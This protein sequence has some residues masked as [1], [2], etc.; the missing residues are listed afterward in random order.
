MADR[1]PGSDSPH[2]RS[3]TVGAGSRAA[4]RVILADCR[5]VDGAGNPWVAA[6]V[7]VEGDLVAAIAPA[8]TIP[9]RGRPAPVVIDVGGR[10]VTPGFVDPHTHSDLTVLTTPAPS[11]RSIR[12]SRPTWW[13]TAACRRRRSTRA[14]WATS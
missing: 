12:G 13:A 9:R 4:G 2:A 14:A 3:R 1:R 8:G 6:D 7:L 5:L 10:Y 11:R